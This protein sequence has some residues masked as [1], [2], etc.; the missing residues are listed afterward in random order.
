LSSGW[1][2]RLRGEVPLSHYITD[3]GFDAAIDSKSENV[4]EALRKACPNGINVYSDNVGGEILEAALANLARGARIV[5][6]GAISQDYNTGATPRPR[7]YMSLLVNRAPMKGML[8]FDYASHFPEAIREAAEWMAE[9]ELG[10]REDIVTGL[11]N[12][13]EAFLKLF[14]GENFG[15]LILKVAED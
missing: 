13:P 3:L 5:I 11:V 4:S 15:K 12:F 10:S 7:N 1:H 2:R 6:C 14:T 8:V 9:G